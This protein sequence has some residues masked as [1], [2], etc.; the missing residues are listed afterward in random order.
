MIS[1]FTRFSFFSPL[2]QF[3][4]TAWLSSRT[5]E[6]IDAYSLH[7]LETERDAWTLLTTSYA[8]S[9]VLANAVAT[10][11]LSSR[12]LPL[13]A[14]RF[15]IVWR[16]FTPQY[17]LPNFP[18][19]NLPASTVSGA[20]SSTLGG[21]SH[22]FLL[23]TIY[24]LTGG[25]V[26]VWFSDLLIPT[27]T[28]SSISG[29]NPTF[30]VSFAPQTDFSFYIDETR[31]SLFLAFFLLGGGEEEEDEDRLLSE[32]TD[33]SF[34]EEIVAPVYLTNLSKN[35][36][37]VAPLYLKRCAIFGFVVANNLRGRIP[38]ADT[39][40]S[41]LGLTLWVS[42]AVFGSLVRVRIRRHGVSYLFRLFRPSGTPFPLLF[43]LI[44]IEFISYTFRVVS[45][46]VRLFANRRA[47]HT[48]RKV[49]IGFAYIFLTIGDRYAVASFLP[50]LVIFILIFL[51]R[52][53]AVIQAYIFVTLRGIYR[54]DIYVGH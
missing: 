39:A 45:L 30:G 16:L 15:A 5:F 36:A 32:E 19:I 33:L 42:T 23:A 53:V 40:T 34:V 52:G 38:Y 48:L 27:T 35:A 41:S 7:V 10:S 9:S 11:R 47:G 44:P 1:A 46:A 6:R 18:S 31:I 25:F 21:F 3:D 17:R 37:E 13:V 4:N 51:E 28:I 24:I 29:V 22:L 49:L 43:L 8:S 2:D 20:I 26:T 14:L 54:K 12:S 50:A